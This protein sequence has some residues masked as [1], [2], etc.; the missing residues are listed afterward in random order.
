MYALTIH[1]R[2]RAR[3]YG[4]THTHIPCFQF[5]VEDT[6]VGLDGEEVTL[7]QAETWA[8]QW[9]QGPQLT[10]HAVILSHTHKHTHSHAHMHVHTHLIA[11]TGF[12]LDCPVVVL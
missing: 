11:F 1:T 4:C 6:L 10:A 2:A 3:T 5:I 8:R 7:L 9:W 12:A